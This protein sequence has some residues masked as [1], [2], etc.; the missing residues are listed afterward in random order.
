M[1]QDEIVNTP[2]TTYENVVVQVR[3]GT[4]PGLRQPACV[5]ARARAHVGGCT[6][7]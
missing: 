7:A 3:R 6:Y 5:D 1:T 2:V 4:S